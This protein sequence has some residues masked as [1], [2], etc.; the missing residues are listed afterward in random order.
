MLLG[1]AA[2]A[3]LDWYV[4]LG[5]TQQFTVFRQ[6]PRLLGMCLATYVFLVLLTHVAARLT[7][8]EA[9]YRGLRL[10]LPTVLRGLHYHAVHYLPVGILAAGTVLGYQLALARGWASGT[11]GAI[12]LYILSAEV[13]VAAGYLFST[14]WTA[15]RNLMYANR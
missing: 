14:Y 10:P 2:W 8:W 3:H 1:S 13:V 15:M 5:G 12:Y 4:T 6:V 7:T 9:G 11:S